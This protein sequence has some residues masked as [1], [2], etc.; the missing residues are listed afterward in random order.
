MIGRG[1]WRMS[2]NTDTKPQKC[3]NKY[4]FEFLPKHL[5]EQSLDLEKTRQFLQKRIDVSLSA[6]GEENVTT[7]VETHGSSGVNEILNH[8]KLLKYVEDRLEIEKT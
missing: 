5:E 6:I 2:A 7:I 3:K 4:S 8:I 1:Y